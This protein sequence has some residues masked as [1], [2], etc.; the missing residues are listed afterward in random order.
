METTKT[1]DLIPWPING[2]SGIGGAEIW[3]KKHALFVVTQ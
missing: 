2:F 3:P 1:F